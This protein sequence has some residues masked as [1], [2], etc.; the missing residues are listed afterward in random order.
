MPFMPVIF[1]IL[2]NFSI[3][4]QKQ[5]KTAQSRPE[6]QGAEDKT[7]KGNFYFRKNLQKLQ[8]IRPEKMKKTVRTLPLFLG[9]E[10]T[11]LTDE[12]LKECTLGVTIPSSN[13]FGSLNLSHAVQIISYHLFRKK[14]EGFSGYTPLSLDRLGK[15]VDVIAD[16]LQKIG[17]FKITG[18]QD[19]EAFWKS[20]LSRAALSESEAKYLEKIFSKAA[21]LAGKN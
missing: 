12:E 15:T 13:S 10:R 21:G 8:K 20:I 7:E 6:R 17:F 3:R 4:L 19:M 16:N 2:L 1:L 5:Q 11:G 9:N 18:R 14:N